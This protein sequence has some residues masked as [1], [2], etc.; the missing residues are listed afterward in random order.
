MSNVHTMLRSE[1]EE[2]AEDLALRLNVP[3][4]LE[5]MG[6]VE[7]RKQ[8]EEW[9][10]EIVSIPVSSTK[11]AGYKHICDFPKCRN[12]T[13]DKYCPHCDKLVK[14]LSR[15]LQK[16]KKQ[17]SDLYNR[18]PD[19]QAVKAGYARGEIAFI[20]Y[21]QGKRLIMLWKVNRIMKGKI[22]HI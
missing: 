1:L 14:L 2:E 12:L 13:S 17:K 15:H 3:C 11:L 20:P 19:L 4:S 9:R 6:L 21:R 8:V 18:Y 16:H 7:Q 5:G 10:R 22:I